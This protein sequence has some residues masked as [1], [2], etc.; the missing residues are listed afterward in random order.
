MEKDGALVE[1]PQT[2]TPPSTASSS[3]TPAPGAHPTVLTWAG[4]GVAVVG[5]AALVGATF[6]YVAASTAFDTLKTER[7]QEFVTA[8][9]DAAAWYDALLPLGVVGVVGGAGLAATSMMM[10][11]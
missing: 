10:A 2:T 6:A 8:N 11:E 9:L 7:K 4:V 5:V 1:V 3:T